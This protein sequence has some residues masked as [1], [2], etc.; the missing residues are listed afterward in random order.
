VAA[1]EK[2]KRQHLD[3]CLTL[4]RAV[5]PAG[6]NSCF[7]PYSIA[8]AL[9]LLASAT[10]GKTAEELTALLAGSADEL[11][12]QADLLRGASELADDHGRE[13][14]VLAVSNTLWAWDQLPL[15]EEFLEV[16]ATWPNGSVAPAT[17]IDDPEN[18]RQ[19]I[20]SDVAKTT[21]G[22]I[23]E[24]LLPG[25]VWAD[26]V[27]ALVNALYLKAAWIHPFAESATKPGDFHSPKR[28]VSVPMMR[29]TESLGYARRDGWQVVTLPGAGGTEAVV[30]L[31]EGDLAEA[32][33]ALDAESLNRLL[34]DTRRVKV[35]LT[36]PKFE[37]DVRTEL[38]DALKALGITTV[39]TGGAD[40]TPLSPDP[41][42]AVYDVLHQAVLRV[43]EQGFEGAAATAV[44]IRTLSMNMADPV[45]VRVDRPFLLVVRHAATGVVYFLSRI[46]EP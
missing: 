33:A 22:L 32:E 6:A 7:S 3:L 39:F 37:V 38:T 21:R 26:A 20:N 12:R 45:V 27:A 30:L 5:A 4:H 24:L 34:A 10:R 15:N 25:T 28:K 16:L 31:P 44:M 19:V 14:P 23:S 2:S 17:F 46:T 11:A 9:G 41:R 40:F 43:G 35:D 18:V 42:L 8:S 1:L 13:K 36:L 29:Q